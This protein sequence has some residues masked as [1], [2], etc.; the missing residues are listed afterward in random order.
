MSGGYPTDYILITKAK[1][2]VQK[3]KRFASQ[4][5]EFENDIL[6]ILF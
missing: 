4:L 1:V 2:Y 3:K 5:R 6:C